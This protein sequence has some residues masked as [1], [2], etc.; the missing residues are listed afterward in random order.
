MWDPSPVCYLKNCHLNFLFLSPF[1]YILKTIYNQLNDYPEQF[2]NI[3]LLFSF[4]KTD[5]DR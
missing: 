2:L 3:A 1:V 4:K 5:H